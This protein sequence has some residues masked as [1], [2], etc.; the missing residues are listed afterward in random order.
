[1]KKI[2][3]ILSTAL[4]T[5]VVAFA[6]LLVGVR[7]FGLTPYTVLSGSMEPNY[8][9]GSLI[10]VKDVNP[11]DLRVDDPVTYLIDGGTVVTH[12][13]IEVIPDEDDPSVV[14]F[15]TKGDNNDDP[16]G[17]L[18]HSNNVIG[19]PVFTIPLLGYVTYFIQNPPG[20][21]FAIGIIASLLILAFLPD[22]LDKLS[23]PE[24]K[25]EEDSP[26]DKDN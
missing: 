1:M 7:I 21:Y 5:V 26:S 25:K 14:R 24:E 22:V 17:S 12:R 15:R 19:M 23:P 4:M 13:I 3:N 10:Y 18:L 11:M 20:N 2:C 8:H 6:V 9:V 16:D